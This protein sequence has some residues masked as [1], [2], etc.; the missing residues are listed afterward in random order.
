MPAWGV[1]DYSMQHGA[2][3]PTIYAGVFAFF[4]G[5]LTRIFGRRLVDGRR[6]RV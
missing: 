2:L 6:P 3:H 1:I 5:L 4:A